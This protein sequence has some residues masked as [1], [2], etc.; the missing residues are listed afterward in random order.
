MLCVMFVRHKDITGS[1]GDPVSIP[2]CW[3]VGVLG[4]VSSRGGTCVCVR[5]RTQ[6]EGRWRCGRPLRRCQVDSPPSPSDTCHH[7]THLYTH[8]YHLIT[9]PVQSAPFF[10]P[11]TSFC[12][13]P[14]GSPHPV[15]ITSSQSPP[16]LS[17]SVTPSTFHS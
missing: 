14:P 17:P 15:H 13:S 16:L 1:V 9:S 11:S 6:P 2:T 4:R 12:Y 5:C 3:F 7:S 8:L 10:I